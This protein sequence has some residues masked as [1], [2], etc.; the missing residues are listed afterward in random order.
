MT[1]KTHQLIS[2]TASLTYFLSAAAPTYNPATF[3]AV[4]VFSYIGALLPDIDQPTGKLWHYLPFGDTVG[5]L[6]DPLMEHRNITHSLLGTA[7]VGVGFY[8]LL[9]SFPAYWG[10]DNHTVFIC[11]MIAYLFHLIADLFTN[12]GIP[13]LFPYHR[14]FGLPPKPLDGFRVSTGKWFENLVIFPI[15]TIYLM[16]FLLAHFGDIKVILFK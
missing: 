4:I 14:F 9:R 1:G 16:I 15:F 10:I 13:I 2:E 3:G 8:F 5:R 12:E 7:I 6:S 11:I